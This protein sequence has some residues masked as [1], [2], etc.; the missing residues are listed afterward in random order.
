MHEFCWDVYVTG[1]GVKGGVPTPQPDTAV[2]SMIT[3]IIA[4][5]VQIFF[6]W[7]VYSLRK[8]SIIVKGVAIIIV[9]LAVEQCTSCVT[10]VGL[11]LHAGADIA[12]VALLEKGT[13]LTKAWLIG[14]VICDL[15]IATA[16][17]TI[18]IQYSRSSRIRQTKALVKSLIVRSVETGTM[19][20][21]FTVINLVL[22][23]LFPNNYLY[24]IFDRSISKLY[25]NALL[26]SLNARQS[27]ANISTTNWNSMDMSSSRSASN[28]NTFGLKVVSSA[29]MKS[30]R[31]FSSSRGTGDTIHV[32]KQTD[33]HMDEHYKPSATYI[34]ETDTHMDNQYKPST[35]FIAESV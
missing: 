16:M 9:L 13:A 11:Y 30:N 29:A 12:S 28:N 10:G 8:E 20:F 15:I 18:L 25:S 1:I 23:L 5:M 3:G 26:L 22:F 32:S 17:S 21:V 7:R 4:A 31:G 2:H 24:M 34:A 14:A 33:V 19:T 35:P 6:A 27:G